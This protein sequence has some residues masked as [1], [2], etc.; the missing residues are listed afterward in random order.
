MDT[1]PTL[2][3][4]IT[5]ITI[6]FALIKS[7]SFLKKAFHQILL[8]LCGDL[9]SLDQLSTYDVT[10]LRCEHVSCV[11]IRCGNQHRHVLC[12][13]ENAHMGFM[14]R[15]LHNFNHIIYLDLCY[16]HTQEHLD[17]QMQSIVT[18]IHKQHV[19]I[20]FFPKLRTLID[21]FTSFICGI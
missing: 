11:E 10:D 14:V 9:C 15:C 20:H 8:Y 1:C 2:Q 18:I 6:Q 19:Q 12:R 5:G 13:S 21:K 3:F 17:H 4:H 16:E 7:F